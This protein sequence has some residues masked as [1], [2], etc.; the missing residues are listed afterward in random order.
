MNAR[1]KRRLNLME[2]KCSRRMCGVPAINKIR[3]EVIRGEVGVMRR[4]GH[5]ERKDADGMAKR[6]YDSWEEGGRGRGRPHRR[7]MDGVVSAL[8]VRGL[9]V[10]QASA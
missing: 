4:F 8:S 10:E 2:M 6:I 7:W 3:N 9:H 1:E 5:V